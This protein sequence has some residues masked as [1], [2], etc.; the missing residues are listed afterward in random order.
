MTRAI[1]DAIDHTALGWVKPEI[2]EALRQARID[3][4]TFAEAP[5][6]TAPLQTIVDHLHQVQ[7]TLRILELQ[8]PAMVAGELEQLAVALHDGKVSASDD[9]LALLMRGMVQLPRLP[10]ASA[11]WAPRHS[12]RP[13]AADQRAA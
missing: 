1:R 12:D 7:G 13:A 5:G 9:V 10:G 11:R 6:E 8:T 4:E 2:D 3:L